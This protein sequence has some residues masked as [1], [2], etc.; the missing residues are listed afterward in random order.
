MNFLGGRND[1][2]IKP[3]ALKDDT[4]FGHDV[5]SIPILVVPGKFYIYNTYIYIYIHIYCYVDSLPH[6]VTLQTAYADTR[7]SPDIGPNCVAYH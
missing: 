6:P 2:L 4:L 7:H 5:F 1:E 3:A